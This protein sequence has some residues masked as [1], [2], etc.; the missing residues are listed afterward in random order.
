MVNKRQTNVIFACKLAF[1]VMNGLTN[2]NGFILYFKSLN[3]WLILFPCA[4]KYDIEKCAQ[5]TD[6]KWP[7]MVFS[8]ACICFNRFVKSNENENSFGHLKIYNLK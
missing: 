4:S 6:K 3:R 1:H 7:G 2:E 5:F 8:S